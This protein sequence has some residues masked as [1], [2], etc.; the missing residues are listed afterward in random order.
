MESA[1]PQIPPQ[2]LLLTPWSAFEGF[3]PS[4][5]YGISDQQAATCDRLYRQMVVEIV[6]FA[7]PWLPDALVGAGAFAFASPGSFEFVL[8]NGQRQPVPEIASLLKMVP[9]RMPDEPCH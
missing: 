7:M 5:A 1:Q 9:W 4:E 6:Q 8:P 2:P 3:S